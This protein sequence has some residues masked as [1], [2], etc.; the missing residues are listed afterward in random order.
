MRDFVRAGTNQ[1]LPAIRL[2]GQ[3]TQGQVW[4]SEMDGRPVAIKVYHRHTAVPEQKAVLDRLIPIGAP[5]RI[6]VWPEA[7]IEDRSEGTYGYVMELIEPRFRDTADFMTRRITPTFLAL[8]NVCR[9]LSNGF[10]RLHVNGLCYRDISFSNLR[11]DPRTGDAKILDNDNVDVDG[12]DP[13]GVNGTPGFMAPEIVRREARSSAETDRYSLAALLFYLLL[14]GH[15]LDGEH[16]AQMRCMNLAAMDEL[17]GT[18][19]VYIFDPDDQTNRPH[20]KI[21]KNPI[22]FAP[23]Y[24]KTIMDLFLRSFTTG[25]RSPRDRVLESDWRHA[26]EDAIDLI[27]PCQFCGKQNFYDPA[28]KRA[29]GS[30]NCWHCRRVLSVPPRIAIPRGQNRAA[31]LVVLSKETR[32]YGYHLGL[33]GERGCLVAVISTNPN[34]PSQ[35]GLQNQTADT[36]NLTK[37]DLGIEGIPP[38]RSVPAVNGNK[39]NFGTTTGEI[40]T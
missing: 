16:E 31:A 29:G 37:P 22:V 13:I 14:G 38:G 1:P 33:I 34:N 9:H 17:Y 8:L 18:K 35:I 12:S 5:D 6:F 2:L 20:P 40:E 7:L 24:P 19:P 15:P 27:F 21:H 39:V 3:G 30:Q 11:F 10:Y 26:F 32:L 23:I 36:W 28:I 25:L 4:Q